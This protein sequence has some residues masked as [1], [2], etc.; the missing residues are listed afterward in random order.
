MKFGKNKTI[1]DGLGFLFGRLIFENKN[2]P[3][4]NGEEA[5]LFGKSAI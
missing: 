5:L 4:S 2:A 3:P 1:G